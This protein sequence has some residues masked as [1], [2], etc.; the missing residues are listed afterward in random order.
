MTKKL[1]TTH[2]KENNVMFV[3]KVDEK[4]KYTDSEFKEIVNQR[5]EAGTIVGVNHDERVAFLEQN[6]YEVTR[7]NML[8]GALTVKSDKINSDTKQK[9]VG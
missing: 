9:D 5:I 3:G 1:L 4:A 6:G 2:E 7:E 8:N